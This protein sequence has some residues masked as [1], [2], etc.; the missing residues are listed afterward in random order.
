MPRLWVK[1]RAEMSP[2]ALLVSNSFVVPEQVPQVVVNVVDGRQTRLHIYSDIGWS[3]STP[4]GA[5]RDTGI[6]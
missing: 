2:G 5:R 3:E 4:A 1:A 6:E